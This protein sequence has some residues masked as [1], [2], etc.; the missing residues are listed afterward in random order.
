MVSL[1]YNDVT[2]HLTVI[3]VKARNLK[4]KDINGLS[5]KVPLLLLVAFAPYLAV[6]WFLYYMC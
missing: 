3:I 5:G 4:A 6:V 2:N 1:S